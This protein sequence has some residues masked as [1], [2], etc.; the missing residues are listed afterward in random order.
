MASGRRQGQLISDPVLEDGRVFLPDSLLPL[1]PRE[2]EG[3]DD[4]TQFTLNLTHIT[5]AIHHLPAPHK[6]PTGKDMFC[7]EQ[8]REAC[9]WWHFDP[10]PELITESLTFQNYT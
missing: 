9:L 5:K 10:P 8:Q 6:T 3:K 1:F 2:L 7:P 4:C